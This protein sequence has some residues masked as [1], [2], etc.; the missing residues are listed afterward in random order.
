MNQP[1]SQKSSSSSSG[2]IQPCPTSTPPPTS[3][4]DDIINHR[5]PISPNHPPMSR[6]ARAA[7]FAP[8]AALVGHRNIIA[9][10]ENNFLSSDD[11]DYIIIK[12]D[13]DI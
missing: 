8:Y 10:D 11:P 4:Y 13:C 6:E 9:T 2:S 7:Q 1:S 12:K 5:R 3:T